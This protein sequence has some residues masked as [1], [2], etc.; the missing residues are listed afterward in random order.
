MFLINF[1][2]WARNRKNPGGGSFNIRGEFNSRGKGLLCLPSSCLC[3]TGLPRR[4]PLRSFGH[5]ILFRF[6]RF[7]F[8]TAGRIPKYLP[9]NAKLVVGWYNKTLPAFIRSHLL[10]GGKEARLAL[11]M[12]S[13]R[14]LAPWAWMRTFCPTPLQFAPN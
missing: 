2:L 3:S 4:R 10:G 6:D 1:Q 11:L 12:S 7:E 13:S 14:A 8:S 9:P 5:D